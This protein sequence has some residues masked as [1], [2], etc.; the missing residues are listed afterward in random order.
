[1]AVVVGCFV[2]SSLYNSPF[3]D[4]EFLSIQYNDFGD[5]LIEVKINPNQ[6]GS[7]FSAGKIISLFNADGESSKGQMISI[8]N[9][10]ALLKI[11]DEDAGEW[12]IPEF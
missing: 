6:E 9:D 10:L 11:E 12:A 4:L 1:M 2:A 3:L 7:A 8:K 5:F